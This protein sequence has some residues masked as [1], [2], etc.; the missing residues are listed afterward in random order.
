MY[1]RISEDKRK[2][3]AG[4]DRQ[5]VEGRR[6]ALA[7]GLTLICDP[8]VEND[9]SAYSGVRRPG[10]ERVMTM[11]A[12]G[13]VDKII[14]WQQSRLWRSR[15]ERAEAIEVLRRA[16]V[17]VVTAK[18]IDLDFST[19]SGRMMAGVVGEVDTFE[20]EV[21]AERVA[22]A[23]AERAA[24]GR[25]NGPAGYGFR[26]VYEP[27]AQTGK[28]RWLATVAHETEA[29]IIREITQRIC[30]GGPRNS[31][32]SITSD[33]NR[34]GVPAPGASFTFTNKN[35]AMVN[36]DGAK[37]SPT[38][39]RKLA[40]RASNAG[41][42][43]VHRG[44][45]DEAL[46]PAAW[47]PLVSREDWESVVRQL[48]DTRRDKRRS[49]PASRQHLLTWGIGYCGVCGG[50]LRVARRGRWGADY[51]RA[52][53]YVC[54]EQNTAG[55]NGKRKSCVGRNEA[56]VD[57]L[58]RAVVLERL[59]RED[60]A[61]LLAD[62]GRELVRAQAK[63]AEL[64]EQA[65]YVAGKVASGEWLP[66]QLDVVNAG[67]LPRLAEAEDELRR[68]HREA[69]RPVLLSDWL[70]SEI[71]ARWDASDVGLRRAILEALGMKVVILPTRRGPGFDPSSVKIEWAG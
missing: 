13:E 33:L 30:D 28:P 38:S 50:F 20:S 55:D 25:A 34:R 66:Q 36:A 40:L 41:L 18:G 35:R 59:S 24:Q 56:A 57:A 3:A 4:V 7:R 16:R 62:D 49:R 45:P 9:R 53:T 21:K 70:G 63:V 46:L 64:R 44:Q 14:V 31:L 27:D 69:E 15:R 52:Q 37:W 58:V 43:M 2:D 48:G 39:V 8:I 26:H 54:A 67:L 71:A 61:D 68:L 65:A 29:A 17:G 60:A 10:Y 11:A 12:A 5:V 32:A 47:K 42:R 19:A 1:A 51:A 6:L 22:L 23:A